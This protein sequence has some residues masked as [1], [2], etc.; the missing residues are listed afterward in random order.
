VRLEAFDRIGSKPI[1]TDV[2]RVVVFDDD[3][4]PIMIVVKYG[5]RL[6]HAC[7]IGDDEFDAMLKMM[8]I[9]RTTVLET[10]SAEDLNKSQP[11]LII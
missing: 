2:T 9:N 7:R 1:R 10:I 4:N 3:D 11:K 8:G 5:P 6:C